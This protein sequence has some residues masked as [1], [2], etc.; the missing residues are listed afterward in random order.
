MTSYGAKYIVYLNKNLLCCP[1][2]LTAIVAMG[3]TGTLFADLEPS[4]LGLG[5][6]FWLS[7]SLLSR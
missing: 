1:E 4:R 5:C 3:W 7:S 6:G 2:S